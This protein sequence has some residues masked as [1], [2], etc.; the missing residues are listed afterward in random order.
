M[1]E[2]KRKIFRAAADF[3]ML[4]AVVAIAS[5]PLFS[6]SL[7]IGY[8]LPIY[9]FFRIEGIKESLL[10]GQFP[11]RMETYA[12]NGYGDPAG[13]F[14]P[15]L[16]LY[17][18]ALLRAA[19]LSFTASFNIFCFFINVLTAAGAWWAFAKLTRSVRVG[20]ICAAMYVCFF[21]RVLAMYSHG[22]VGEF[23]AMA[24]W[25]IAVAGILLTLYRSP[26]F[27]PAAVIGA[28]GILESHVISSVL[29]FGAIIITLL[30]SYKKLCEKSVL[31]A[32]G[33]AMFFTMILNVWFYAPFY[34]LYQ[35]YDFHQKSFA[36][37]GQALSLTSMPWSEIA[38]MQMFWGYVAIL[39]TIVY[40]F[41]RLAGKFHGEKQKSRAK[42]FYTALLIGIFFLF[43]VSVTF[44]WAQL[45]R[46]PVVG[47]RFGVMQWTFR[48]MILGEIALSFCV[49][50]AVAE[51]SGLFAKKR[52]AAALLCIVIAASNIAVLSWPNLKAHLGNTESAGVIHWNMVDDGITVG[53]YFSHI[54]LAAPDLTAKYEFSRMTMKELMASPNYAAFGLLDYQ[55][56]DFGYDDMYAPPNDDFL[57]IFD[58]VAKGETFIPKNKIE[59]DA[60][61]FDFEKKG[62]T[63]KFSYKADRETV[64]RLP[65]FYFSDYE[66]RTTDG[67]PLA[68]S[69]YGKHRLQVTLPAG[70]NG[71]ELRFVGRSSWRIWL[72]ISV[73]G[74][75]LF[76]F[77]ARREAKT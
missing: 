23:T 73:A 32:T 13:L 40:I 74:L 15:G 67:R 52:I 71:V 48:M 44:P 45:E 9:H 26:R 30:V 3:F 41:L 46:L 55:P 20:A 69:E 63:V 50:I 4:A 49:G 18:P 5:A 28:T 57:K 24:F 70:E 68:V 38:T 36:S 64:A 54:G 31:V 34:E 21:F 33:K 1:T 10:G 76:L 43:S 59:S 37:T 75:I 2:S 8:D 47:T 66:A 60:Q 17:V 29:L 42:F 7:T 77:A 19:G 72:A 39:V 56:A 16:M 22:A 53:E 61:I 6:N 65:L 51:L 27:W 25:P 12:F 62:A 14:Y 58:H 11:M 35:T